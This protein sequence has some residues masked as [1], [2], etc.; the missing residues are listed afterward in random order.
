MPQT[1]ALFGHIINYQTGAVLREA[2][3]VDWEFAREHGE[4][5]TGAFTDYETGE[6]VYCDGPEEMDVN[7]ARAAYVERFESDS[8]ATAFEEMVLGCGRR[9]L[10]SE[11]VQVLEGGAAAASV[12]YYGWLIDQHAEWQTAD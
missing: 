5:H 9:F 7:M 4:A 11:A 6:T 8:D 2:N 12:A 1:T 3:S 10:P